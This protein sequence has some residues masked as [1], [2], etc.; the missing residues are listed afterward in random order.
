MPFNTLAAAR[1]ETRP[2]AQHH[3]LTLLGREDLASEL[4]QL[5]QRA[6]R[7]LEVRVLRLHV[8]P[9]EVRGVCH[10][11]H[12]LHA[13]RHGVAVA[14]AHDLVAVLQQSPASLDDVRNVRLVPTF[15]APDQERQPHVEQQAPALARKEVRV[16]GE[17]PE[18][19]HGVVLDQRLLSEHVQ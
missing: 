4:S 15:H 16:L 6:R 5:L 17:L 11:N 18:H 3:T 13:D 12:R 1:R 19:R 2:I 10:G 14:A 8:S 9:E 7:H